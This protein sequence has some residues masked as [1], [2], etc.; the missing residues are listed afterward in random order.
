MHGESPLLLRNALGGLLIVTRQ[1]SIRRH[2]SVVQQA[3][4]ALQTCI[5]YRRVRIA[6]IRLLVE[7]TG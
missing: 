5:R 4:R 6:G 7:C 3:V 2:T 1:D